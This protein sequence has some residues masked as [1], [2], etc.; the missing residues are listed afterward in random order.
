MGD[1]AAIADLVTGMC[2]S[3]GFQP[4][5]IS[6]ANPAEASS[7]S[8]SSLESAAAEAAS[9]ALAKSIWVGY[10]HDQASEAS[11]LCGSVDPNEDFELVLGQT[12]SEVSEAQAAKSKGFRSTGNHTPYRARTAGLRICERSNGGASG[13]ESPTSQVVTGK[14]KAP[15]Y[16]ES[17]EEDPE[18]DDDRRELSNGGEVI[19]TL[20]EMG[21][22]PAKVAKAIKLY[23]AVQLEDVGS[24]LDILNNV[25]DAELDE[26]LQTEDGADNV[27]S[28]VTQALQNEE[29]TEHNLPSKFEQL[30]EMGYD[31]VKCRRA[32]D[33]YGNASICEL[34]DFLDALGEEHKDD[35]ELDVEELFSRNARS[36]SDSDDE[37]GEE[38]K[39][40]YK[41]KKRKN[42]T[43]KISQ[44]VKNRRLFFPGNED[45]VQRYRTGF[46]L[47]GDI[48]INRSLPLD[49]ARPPYF[50]F[51]NVQTMPVGEWDHIRRHLFSIEPEILDSLH[52]SACRRP[53]GYIH[54]LPLEGRELVLDKPPMTIQELMGSAGQYWPAWDKRVKL[55]TICTRLA[56]D[57]VWRQ[58]KDP[59]EA[60]G[61][62]GYP[63]EDEKR[64]I[65]VLARKWNL[66]WVKPNKLVPLSPEEVERCLGFDVD[67]TRMLYSPVD[68]I[69]VL[70]NSFQVN[71]VAYQLSVLR[72]RYPQGMK[73]LS[74]FSGIGG[75]EVAL[76]KLG[77]FLKVVVS[78]EIDEKARSVLESWWKTSNQKGYLMHEYTDGTQSVSFFE[79]PRI[80][81]VVR[82]FMGNGGEASATRFGSL[83]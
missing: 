83:R 60:C 28:N 48:V 53:R 25:S 12:A 71:T 46:G 2:K 15:M 31:S 5:A 13:L 21:Y 52:F 70:G 50:F 55:N 40:I 56:T 47:P 68:R 29:V 6:P 34:C 8:G 19:E 44:A 35:E 64:T 16:Q 30:L 11:R 7:S 33:T 51:E 72:S 69:R 67:H 41:Q 76:H 66:V 23:G 1:I 14:G 32:V 10:S 37:Y 49:V 17:D 74:L 82:E 81:N 79:F 57:S 42:T 80:L 61:R 54:N 75:A 58:I 59:V 36:S 20:V 27:P 9:E 4:P 78:I 22:P 18:P 65:M 73:V 24:L 45:V 43:M 3:V 77:I 39:D 26:A 38:V 63:T 62:R